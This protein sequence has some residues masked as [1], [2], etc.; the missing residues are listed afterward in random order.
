MT[1]LILRWTVPL[2]RE[3]NL[4]VVF[5]FFFFFA[6]SCSHIWG[7][8]YTHLAAATDNYNTTPHVWQ[9]EPQNGG[10]LL[11]DHLITKLCMMVNIQ[12][13][14]KLLISFCCPPNFCLKY[15]Y[16]TQEDK[17]DLITTW[18]PQ[19]KNK[20]CNTIQCF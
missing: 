8:H 17:I 1:V 11:H 2:S 13:I 12:R 3:T 14:L 5:F 4:N 6:D 10:V 16:D 7:T 18:G 9:R 15:S 19:I 20:R